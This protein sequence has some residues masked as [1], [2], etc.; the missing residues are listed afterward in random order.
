[1]ASARRE[2]LVHHWI[3]DHADFDAALRHESDRDAELRDAADEIRRSVDR[4]DNPDGSGE[5]ATALLSVERIRGKELRKPVPDQLL[6]FAVD[7][8]EIVL[9]SLEPDLQGFRA[10]LEMTARQGTGSSESQSGAARR[11]TE[12][13]SNS[14]TS[15]QRRPAFIRFFMTVSL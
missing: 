4:I 6:D 9:V 10:A 5:T 12:C 3:V 7:R 11:D 8:G 14:A 15:A 13:P 1:M 2:Q